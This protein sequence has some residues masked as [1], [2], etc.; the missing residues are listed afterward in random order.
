MSRIVCH[1]A[2]AAVLVFT[3]IGAC[4]NDSP[5]D[6][7]EGKVAAERART[8]DSGSAGS[9][10]ST[11]VIGGAAA[12]TPADA[13]SVTNATEYKLTDDNFRRFIAASESLAVLRRRDPQAAAY[14]DQQI[15]DAG[16]GTRVSA[17]DA[18]RKHLENNPAV[19]AA[20]NAAGISEKDYLVAS[21]AIAQAERFIGDP[22]AAPPTPALGPNAQFLGAHRADLDRLHKL[23]QP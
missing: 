23:R 5:A 11:P 7:K 1:R 4:S 17:N 8:A 10:A 18:G 3:A 15:N 16:S 20:I 21:I 12:V 19:S 22:K 6:S 2:L 9:S 14:L 13:K